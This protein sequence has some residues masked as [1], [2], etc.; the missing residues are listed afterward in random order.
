MGK[1]LEDSGK[2][3]NFAVL[4]GNPLSNRG[5]AQSGSAPGLG[6]GGRRFESCHPDEKDTA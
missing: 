6:P 4:K 5:V 1:C 3:I 2:R